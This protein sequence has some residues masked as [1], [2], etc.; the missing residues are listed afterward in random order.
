MDLPILAP[1]R[2]LRRSIYGVGAY[3]ALNLLLL[4]TEARWH[5][6]YRLTVLEVLIAR[7]EFV[8]F[9]HHR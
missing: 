3:W 9:I 8:R 4:I 1:Y 6:L 2:F 5:V 7:Y